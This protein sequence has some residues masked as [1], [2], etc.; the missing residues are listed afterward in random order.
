MRQRRGSRTDR[1]LTNGPGKLC[2]AFGITGPLHHGASLITS[3]LRILRGEPVPESDVAITKRIGIS[4]AAHE[5]LR[6]I[7]RSSPFVSGRRMRDG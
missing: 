4:K 7:V 5:P 3:P 1:E 2:E 6:W